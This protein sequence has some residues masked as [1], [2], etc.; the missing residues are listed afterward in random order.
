M[1]ILVVTE[2]PIEIDDFLKPLKRM[3]DVKLVI[4]Q[5]GAVALGEIRLTPPAFVIVDEG[6]QDFKPLQ[7]I[8]EIM[9]INAMINTAVVSALSPEEFH[10]ASE[11][12]G[13]LAPIPL[14][15]NENDGLELV[16]L[17]ARFI[18][19]SIPGVTPGDQGASIH[20]EKLVAI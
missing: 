15:P 2:R 1:N 20:Q 17:F 16:T 9:K 13:I 8:P 3:H 18:Y 5:N 4:A 7:L 10:E 19:G 12:L 14:K 11:G 6:L